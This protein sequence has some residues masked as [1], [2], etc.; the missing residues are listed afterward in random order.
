MNDLDIRLA[1]L[2]PTVRQRMKEL[3]IT[4]GDEDILFCIANGDNTSS[5]IAKTL[6]SPVQ[7][8]SMRLKTLREKGYLTRK[9]VKSP[10]GGYQFEY[11]SIYSFKE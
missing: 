10:S 11:Q 8:I 3:S 6:S 2:N 5:Q 9:E 1:M 4:K 7:T